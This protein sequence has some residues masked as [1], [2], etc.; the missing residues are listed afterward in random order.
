MFGEALKEYKGTVLFVSHDRFF[1]NALA[2]KVL[3]IEDCKTKPYYGNICFAFGFTLMMI[4]DVA[5][6]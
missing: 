6:G 2:N 3:N 4:L 5:L 1:I